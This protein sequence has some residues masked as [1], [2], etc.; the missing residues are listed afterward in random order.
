MDYV[1]LARKLRPQR[2]QDLIGQETVAR[3]LRNAL[4]TGRVAHAFLFAGSR[5]VGK[6]SAARI[7]TKALN[8]QNPQEGEPCNVCPL[9]VEIGAGAA[10]DVYE[11]DAASNRG[12]DN[13]RELRENVKYAPAK[14]AYKTYIIDEAHMLTLEAFNAL[15]KTLEE[16]PPHV[17]FILATTQPHKIPDTILSRCQ[18][19]DFPRIPL[20]RMVDYLSGVTAQEGLTFSRAALET[21]ARNSAGGMRDALTG[22]DQAVA[23]AG[24]APS[25][26]DVLG[27]LGLMDNREVLNLLAAVL[28]RSL[29]QAL[30]AFSLIT[31]RGHDPH[32]LLEA[33][34]REVK[35]L[36]LYRTLGGGSA[37]FQD[38]LQDSRQFYE[39][40]KGGGS[41]D[42]LQQLF[43]L[44]VQL[45]SQLKDSAFSRACFE[46]ALVQACRVQPLVG[47]PELLS[48]ARELLRGVP[49]GA[50]RAGVRPA[51]PAPVEPPRPAPRAVRTPAAEPLAA[52]SNP[53]L[54][55]PTPRAPTPPA[56]PRGS[57]A[58]PAGEPGDAD[59]EG[60]PQPA[61][62]NEAPLPKDLPRELPASL[63][64]D[65]RWVALVQQ[66][67]GSRMLAAKLRGSEV[68]TI[69]A[70]TVEVLIQGTPLGEEQWA[71]LQTAAQAAFGES[72]RLVP[73]H[74]TTRP[75]S[76][77]HTL[78]G[79]KQIREALEQEAQRQAALADPA[80]QHLRR[81]FPNSKVVRVELAAARPAGSD[82]VQG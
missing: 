23:F 5:G 59:D 26:A 49:E 82:D 36:A 15:L 16:P 75:P 10:P 54:R 57:S 65:P 2:F 80:V 50:P 46:M 72:F 18:R 71:A 3:A 52:P 62:A 63:C 6:T 34:V 38:H 20:A 19:Y 25:D 21:I 24:N 4:T 70:D 61:F 79:R 29:D 8:C 66:A 81:L 33:L 30:D 73:A 48:R 53:T 31:A 47:V 32:I 40:R 58:A 42:E 78:A 12:I 76:D 27:L 35:D 55:A 56:R 69:G 44:F 9:C 37:Y 17:E 67:G 13:I 22:I 45:E 1:V 7:L 11:I 14:C 41:L 39:A 51:R 60:E 77:E 68:L 74:G 28:D 64:E 43:Q